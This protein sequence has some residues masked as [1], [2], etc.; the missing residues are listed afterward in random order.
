[1]NLPELKCD[2]CGGSSNKARASRCGSISWA[3]C[4]DCLKS[5]AEPYD[6]MVSYF[7]LADYKTYDEFKG[8]WKKIVDDTLLRIGKTVEQFNIDLDKETNFN[9]NEIQ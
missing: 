2:V 5:H 4:D 8:S 3:Y 6:A 7:S 1:M 9:W